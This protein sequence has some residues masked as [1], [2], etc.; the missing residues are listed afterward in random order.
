VNV[1]IPKKRRDG[2]TSFTKLVSYISDRADKPEDD[3]PLS[4][5]PAKP[6]SQSKQAVF[7]RLVD[8]I[9]RGG[10]AD[11]FVTIM[12]TF[13]DGRQRALCGAVHCETSCFSWE[14]AA[15]EMNMV[16]AQ[17]R[18]CVDPVYHFILSWREGEAP[19]RE[20]VFESARHCIDV[21]GMD[22]HQY[23]TAIHQDTD[24]LHCH[25]AVNRV[26]P[27]TY[28]A[29]NLWNDADKLQKACRVLERKYGF[30]ADNGSWEWGAEDE[31][32]R[33][34]SRPRAVPQSAVKMEAYSDQES[35]YHYTARTVRAPL[36]SMLSVDTSNTLSWDS[37]HLTLHARGLGLREQGNGLVVYDYLRPEATPVK[38]SSVHP[39]LSKTNLEQQ[40]GSFKAP[41]VF[42]PVDPLQPRYGIFQTYTP[43][44]RLRDL[45]ARDERRAE[46]AAEREALKLRYEFYRDS[47]I[48]PDLQAD[49]RRQHIGQ[50]C[51]QSKAKIRN[52]VRD[53]LLRKLMYRAAEFERL[54]AMAEL[55]IQLRT[56]REQLA[57]HGL[58]R[59]LPYRTWV[60]QQA[61]TG[62][63]AAV[64]QLR[65]FSYRERR[66]ERAAER[67]LDRVILCSRGDDLPA[68]DM[69]SHATQI[70]RNGSIQYLRA[71]RPGVIDTG[72]RIEVLK[73][74]EQHDDQAN[75]AVA[76]ELT[77]LKRG[78][79][80]TILGDA[81][82][83]H[84]ALYTAVQCSRAQEDFR[85]QLADTELRKRYEEM[86]RAV[87]TPDYGLDARVQPDGYAYDNELESG[88]SPITPK[89][90]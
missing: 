90:F 34:K 68:Y 31:L 21:L 88:H 11:Q 46:R 84:Q 18:R 42:T 7:D 29:A 4:D 37:I 8:Y 40:I 38:A 16:A 64:S 48:K 63:A 26:N 27:I 58:Y 47:W 66:R 78:G 74:F 3:A 24:N 17:N 1:I 75:H 5:T 9:D 25:V 51:R 39:L 45:G 15:A 33:S 80:V 54:K 53:P 57:S 2:G 73:G 23:V 61:L 19:T 86:Q 44:F 77:S 87:S 81:Q 12:E 55:R 30:E 59:P 60:E 6:A 35:L 43:A 10:S 14:T 82:F 89:T 62:D 49:I 22:G 20:Q 71:G 36:D 32:V 13:E 28:R 50:A 85:Y 79:A 41:P 72:T 56:E 67:A 69:S 76:A 70:L 83:T 65:G 52:A